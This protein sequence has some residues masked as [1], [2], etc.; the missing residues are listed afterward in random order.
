M[1]RVAVQYKQALHQCERLAEAG[2]WRARLETEYTQLV[3]SLEQWSEAQHAWY[4]TKSTALSN[5]LHNDI[6]AV[7]QRYEELKQELQYKRNA[8]QQLLNQFGSLPPQPA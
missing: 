8:W 5:E 7:K 1:T 2:T 3:K 6:A 4:Q